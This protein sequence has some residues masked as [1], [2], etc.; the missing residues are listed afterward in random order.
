MTVNEQQHNCK[1]FIPTMSARIK[2]NFDFLRL[3]AHSCKGRARRRD[4]MNFANREEMNS[5]CECVENFFVW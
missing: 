3:L 4:L 2:K 5:I 1:A